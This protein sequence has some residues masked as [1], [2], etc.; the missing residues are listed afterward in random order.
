VSTFFVS[1]PIHFEERLAEELNSFWFEMMDLD[2]Q[3]TREP[4]PELNIEPGGV[5]F[6]CSDHL[7]Y[8][9]NL[10]S[11]LALRV[12]VRIH[13]FPARFYDQ[14]EK[15]LWQMPLDKWLTE[16]N[17]SLK[18]ETG[19][20]RLN[21]ERNLI[22]AA[23][24]ALGSLAFKVS[25]EAKQQLYIRI[26]KDNAVI[27]L[28]T[29]GENLHRRG[30]ALFRGEA[31]LRENLAALMAQQ[32]FKSGANLESDVF[33]DPFVGSGTILFEIAS[34]KTPN[35]NRKY[36]WL[37]FKNKPKIFNSESWKKNLRWIQ[38]PQ[39]I[40]LIGIDSDEKA[41]HN[42]QENEKHFREIF[43]EIGFQLSTLNRD[44]LGLTSSDFPENVWI[45]ANPPYGI[46][47]KQDAVPKVFKHLE[48]QRPLAGAII[49]HPESM[50]I[51]FQSLSL[52]SQIDF[53]N[54]GLKIKLS[55][56]TR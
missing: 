39:N 10:F 30:Y 20:S 21:H 13:K 14:F 8:Q 31:P 47:L 26:I 45:V 32:L 53:S 56:F 17:I 40:R 25:D 19:K 34:F 54:Q 6:K 44:S 55:V 2:G 33:L 38:K 27:S 18:I 36:S 41:I 11:K 9:I 16:K 48:N 15:E 4:L 46:R 5:E 22:E 43:P 24:K 29:A 37:E 28:D 1:C 42:L 35:L 7:G 3:P 49:L 23:T 52:S 51:E 50:K 12:L